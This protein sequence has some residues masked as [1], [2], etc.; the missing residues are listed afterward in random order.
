MQVGLEAQDTTRPV[1][2][3]QLEATRY[4]ALLQVLAVAAEGRTQPVEKLVVLVAA[5]ATAPE[6]LEAARV[7][8]TKA[9]LAGMA[10]TPQL[11]HLAAAVVLVPLVLH[12]QVVRAAR[13]ERVWLV[14]SRAVRL[15]EAVVAVAHLLMG[16]VPAVVLAVAAR[17]VVVPT[18]E[19]REPSIRAAV[20]AVRRPQPSRV[21][22]RV[23]LEAL[24]SSS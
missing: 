20:V 13:V 6:E 22:K 14:P 9:T 18:T 10:E 7:L 19:P 1:D 4:S 3:V 21:R 11:C 8:Q 15:R 23:V 2:L 5:V 17:V 12:Q 16:Q 24:A